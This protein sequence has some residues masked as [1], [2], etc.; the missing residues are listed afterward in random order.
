MKVARP[1]TVAVGSKGKRYKT[2]DI[3][4]KRHVNALMQSGNLTDGK[5]ATD[6]DRK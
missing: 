4:E 3:P 6:G 2:G 1:V 5:E